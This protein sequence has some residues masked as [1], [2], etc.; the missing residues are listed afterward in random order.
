MKVYRQGEI[1]KYTC[2]LC[3]QP[4]DVV[5]DPSQLVTISTTDTCGLFKSENHLH[6]KCFAGIYRKSLKCDYLDN[7]VLESDKTSQKVDDLNLGQLFRFQNI[8][9]SVLDHEVPGFDIKLD[10]FVPSTLIITHQVFNLGQPFS[11]LCNNYDCSYSKDYI[12]KQ[13]LECFK[14][15]SHFRSFSSNPTLEY[16][17]ILAYNQYER[18]KQWIPESEYNWFLKSDRAD[19]KVS[20]V[21]KLG[22]TSYIP[23]NNKDV[24]LGVRPILLLPASTRI[25]IVR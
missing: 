21:T 18:Y 11:D 2:D 5:L 15:T 20:Y 24:S 19:H 1:Y 22:H 9:F 6:C 4:I 7:K 3:G 23:C 14:S 13:F 25:E 8:E 17:N 12:N 16:A 10:K